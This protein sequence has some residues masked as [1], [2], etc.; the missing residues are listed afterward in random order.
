MS[1]QIGSLDSSLSYPSNLQ[2][3]SPNISI[4]D[5]TPFPYHHTLIIHHAWIQMITP[6]T[7]F[8]IPSHSLTIPM[9]KLQMNSKIPSPA[10]PLFRN[11]F[12]PL[13]TPTPDEPSP[14]LSSYTDATSILSPMISDQPDP[15]RT[16]NEELK[17]ELDIFITLQ[18]QLHYPNTLTIHHLSRSITSSE[19]TNPASTIEETRAHRVFKRKHPKTPM[20]ANPRP[21][22]I[23]SVHPLHANTQEFLQMCLP[24]FP[25]YTYYQTTINELTLTNIP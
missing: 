18:Q 16:V 7:Q 24:Y 8:S 11:P 5:L 23:F 19:S 17:N 13:H 15:P 21:P 14:A 3:H 12:S 2:R 1:H 9:S 22:R 20:L 6:Q 25:Q 4:S 10:R